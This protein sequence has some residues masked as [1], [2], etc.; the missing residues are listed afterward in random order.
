MKRVLYLCLSLFLLLPLLC[1]AAVSAEDVK[2]V[3]YD[4]GNR[5]SQTQYEECL[6]RLNQAAKAT[7]MNVGVILGTENRSDLTIESVAR[8]SYTEL[9]GNNTN[10]I[11][12][13]IDLK[14]SNPYDYIAT[15]GMGQFYYTNSAEYNRIEDIFTAVDP[16]LYP[17]GN[18]DIRGAVMQFAEEVEYYYNAGIPEHYYYYDDETRRYYSIGDDGK[19]VETAGKPYRDTGIIV[20]MILLF[21]GIGVL[22]AVITFFAVKSRYKFKYALSPTNYVNRKNVEFYNQYD[23][24]VHTRQSKVHLN[25]DSGGRS[26]G[27]HHS[28]GHSH[29]GF[30]GGGHH[31]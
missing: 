23:N 7:G 28:G 15:R 2:T 4:E 14:G 26:G 10:G 27:S 30:G 6:T 21:T 20:G 22:A 12:Y 19:I 13:Y 5:L 24:H 17:A 29:G 25:S 18:E 16:Y 11:I 3:L 9:F 1:P 31:R 8:S